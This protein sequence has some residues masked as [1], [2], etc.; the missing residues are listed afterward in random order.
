MNRRVLITPRTFGKT[1]PIPVA[2]LRKAG[3]EPVFNPFERPLTQD[4]IIPL[5][6][7]TDGIIVGLDQIGEEAL[8]HAPRL[9][10]IS[11]YGA[12][13]NNIDLKAAT[14]R[15]II[16]TN[17]PGVN[18]SAVAEL[19]VGL[20]L[21]VARH[22]SDSDRKM[23]QGQ[24]GRHLGFELKE[25]VLGII[26]T[27]QIGKQLASKVRGFDMLIIAHDIEPDYAWA[28]RMGVSYV[29][30]SELISEADIISLHLPLTE[31]TYRMIGRDELAR[32][33]PTAVLIN[34]SRG[35][36]VDEQALCTAL[37]ENRLL[38]AGLDVYEDEPLK[39]SLLTTF[40][41][42]VLTSH[43]GAHTE[44]AVRD[45]GRTAVLNLMKVLNG[46]IPEHIVNYE[47]NNRAMKGL[48]NNAD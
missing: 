16:V 45:M 36:M 39:D 14:E 35:E 7:E 37:K 8:S 40:D 33:K 5:I 22:I 43:I 27:G 32:F 26:G 6:R 34:T 3:Y 21:D 25:K 17:T 24:W 31:D 12:G 38:G 23:R 30:F 20:M 42:V 28:T 44:E 10:V 13:V 46:E 48:R 15:G 4:E 2:L 47:V 18:S 29:T 9:R 19:T 11:K 1:D 41:N